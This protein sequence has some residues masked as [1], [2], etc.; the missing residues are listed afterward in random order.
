MSFEISEDAIFNDEG[1]VAL[2]YTKQASA[3]VTCP[4]ADAAEY[5]F[6]VRAN[7]SAAYVNEEDVECMLGVKEGCCGGRKKNVIFYIDETHH[8][9]W[10]TGGGR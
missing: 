4:G 7:I 10:E 9:R 6:T 5:I 2:R 1:Q 8:R 3:L